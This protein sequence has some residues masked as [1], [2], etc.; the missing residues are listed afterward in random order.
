MDVSEDSHRLREL[1]RAASHGQ[2]SRE[3]YLLQRAALIDRHAGS[4]EAPSIP[5]P[6]V[7][8]TP[9]RHDLWLGVA[10]VIIAMI[11]AAGV[12]LVIF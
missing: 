2:L 10:A 5:L 11:A 3:D 6:A 12:L 1:A 7:A 9:A 8:K 4:D